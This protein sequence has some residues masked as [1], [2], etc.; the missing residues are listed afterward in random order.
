LLLGQPVSG[1]TRETVLQQ[2]EDATAQ[3]QAEK[4]FPIKATDPEM[5]AGA[6]PGGSMATQEDRPK[7]KALDQQA[8]VMAGLLLGSPEFQRR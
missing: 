1:R 5:M 2:F 4:N 7:V 3:Q 6:L 8:A